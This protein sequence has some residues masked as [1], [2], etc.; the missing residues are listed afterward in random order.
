VAISE[1]RAPRAPTRRP[2]PTDESERLVERVIRV[3]VGLTVAAVLV[4]VASEFVNYFA[5]DMEVWALNVDADNNAFAWASSVAQFTVAAFCL[6]LLLAG[7]WSRGPLL[8][9]IAILIFFSVDDIVRIHEQ[10]SS[11]FREDVLG[12]GGA[13]GRLVWPIIFMPLLAAAFILLWR[14]SE[15]A[16]ALAG[17]VTRIGLAMLVLAVFAEAFSTVLHLGEGDSLGTAPD[18]VEVA[19]EESLELAAWILIAGAVA[20][21]VLTSGR[22]TA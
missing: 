20:A 13:W 22:R 9:L 18:V 10:V 6:L 3:S 1:R 2:S 7:W 12:V 5:F 8:G 21:T 15:R 14:F 11:A 17:R 19:V 16:P 4:Q